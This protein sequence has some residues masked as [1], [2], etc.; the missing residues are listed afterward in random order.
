[1]AHELKAR[2]AWRTLGVAAEHRA[3]CPDGFRLQPGTLGDVA[4]GLVDL[5]VWCF[6]WD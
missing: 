6:W 5:P 1:M 4:R 3:F 2:A